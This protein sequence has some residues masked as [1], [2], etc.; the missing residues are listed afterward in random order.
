MKTYSQTAKTAGHWLLAL[1]IVAMTTRL[2][3][4]DA[5]D[6]THPPRERR[7]VIATSSSG[8]GGATAAVGSGENAITIS[9]IEPVGGRDAAARKDRPWL[10]VSIG[11]GSEA[12]T[13]Q[14][15]LPPGAGLVVTY[16][17]PESPAAKA[18]L[19]KNDV[20]V[21]LDSNLLVVPT[22]LRKL[23]QV[24]K[25][26]DTI[27]LVFYRAG[28]RQS[29][30]ATLSKAPVTTSWLGGNPAWDGASGSLWPQLNPDELHLQ[31][32]QFRDALGNQKLDLSQ[33]EEQVRQGLEKAR[34]A[35]RASSNAMSSSALK[36]LR[37]LHKSGVDVENNASVT[38]RNTGGSTRS[39]V[40]T[41]E[42]GTI[43]LVCNP[44]P[45]LTAHDQDGKLLFDGEIATPEQRAK[46]PPDLMEK[47]QPLLNKLVPKAEEDPELDSEAP[48]GNTG[49][50]RDFEGRAGGRGAAT[51]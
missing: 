20:L 49:S 43:V 47:V 12:L 5:E 41:D 15:G 50:F 33:V 32:K 45:R 36:L 10:G 2:R 6:Q 17:A 37:E 35:W 34:K 19:E 4:A 48:K 51:L 7:V 29:T 38:V 3:A 28:K 1:A 40:K 30:S 8:G 21:E 27:E 16:V 24:H 39:I 18:G 31:L 14:L 22:Q 46:V 11:E 42:T 23:V 26:G 44:K 25:E 9:S 13:A